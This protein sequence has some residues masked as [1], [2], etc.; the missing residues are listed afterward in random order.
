MKNNLY[1]NSSGCYDPTAGEAMSNIIRDERRERKK[2]TPQP[3]PY[4]PKE[5]EKIVIATEQ[6]K[7]ITEDK[8]DEDIGV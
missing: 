5:A 6:D 2:N 1:R 4:Q 3:K 7:E 8:T